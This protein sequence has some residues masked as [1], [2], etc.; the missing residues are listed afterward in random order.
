MINPATSDHIFPQPIPEQPKQ[1]GK[2]SASEAYLYRRGQQSPIASTVVNIPDEADD[3]EAMLI[4]THELM[5]QFRVEVVP[6]SFDG[7]E[8]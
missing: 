8:V 7:D 1:A 3:E 6:G 5:K 2:T 4:A